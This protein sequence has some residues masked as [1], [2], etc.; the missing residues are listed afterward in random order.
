MKTITLSGRIGCGKTT[1]AT[2]LF[3]DLKDKGLHV[4]M[5][6]DGALQE[7]THPMR[8]PSSAD[9]KIECK[10]ASGP[11]KETTT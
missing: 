6:D 11:L 10:Y 7:S 2:Q 4:L 8:H 3:K 9:V 1:R 5:F